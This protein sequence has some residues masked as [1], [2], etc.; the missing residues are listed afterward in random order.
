MYIKQFGEMA[1]TQYNKTPKC[2]RSDRGKEYVNKE[3]QNCL[4]GQGIKIQYTAVYSPQ[5]NGVE[6]RKTGH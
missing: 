4:K 3:L 2:I 5:Q 6:E 1:K